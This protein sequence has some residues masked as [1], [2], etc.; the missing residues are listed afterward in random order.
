MTR[1]AMPLVSV[2]FSISLLT[3][4]SAGV[5]DVGQPHVTVSG[6]SNV[7]I[8]SMSGGMVNLGLSP[9]EAKALA[10]STG[11]ELLKHLGAIVQRLNAG[12]TAGGRAENISL[13]VVEAFL[14]TLKGKKVPQSASLPL[15]FVETA[16]FGRHVYRAYSFLAAAFIAGAFLAAANLLA[17]GFPGPARAL[18]PE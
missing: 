9:L 4:S 16:T 2:L 12:Q 13:G 11:Q 5:A 6:S 14:A 8:G 7:G 3:N 18:V 1:P 17:I 15:Q 10:T